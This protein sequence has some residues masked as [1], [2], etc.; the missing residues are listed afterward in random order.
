MKFFCYKESLGNGL[1]LNLSKLSIKIVT[2]KIFW[3]KTVHNSTKSR[4]ACLLFH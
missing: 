1:D 2:K 4:A 3:S